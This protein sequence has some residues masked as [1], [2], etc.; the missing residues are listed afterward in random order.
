MKLSLYNLSAI[1]QDKMILYNSLYKN[2]IEL[3]S[4]ESAIFSDL[5]KKRLNA[6]TDE[7]NDLLSFLT[8]QLIPES[9]HFEICSGLR[10]ACLLEKNG[11][12]ADLVF[13]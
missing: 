5:K 11:I 10:F 12:F 3:G 2:I 4:T 13:I 7:E 6:T 9:I 8:D 1:E